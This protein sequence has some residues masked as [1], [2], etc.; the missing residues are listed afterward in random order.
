MR[1]MSAILTRLAAGVVRSIFVLAVLLGASFAEAAAPVSG[2]TYGSSISGVDPVDVATR[3][4]QSVYS[5]T[6][7]VTL[8]QD[9]GTSRTYD[10]RNSSNSYVGQRTIGQ[11]SV[12]LYPANSRPVN[13]VCQD[14]P[15]TSCSGYADPV[16]AARAYDWLKE[17]ISC[18]VVNGLATCTGTSPSGKPDSQ[19][20]TC[21][22]ANL[23]DAGAPAPVPSPAPP[24]DVDYPRCSP[25]TYKYTDTDG[26]PGC[27]A[28]LTEDKQ[29]PTCASGNVGTVNG[30]YTCL[31][32]NPAPAVADSAA[33][34]AQAKADAAKANPATDAAK[35]AAQ[36][37]AADAQRAVDAANSMASNAANAAAVVA[38][39]QKAIDAAKQAAGYAGSGYGG[40]TKA[41][42]GGT[43]GGGGG[44]AAGTD[45]GPKE[46]GT[47]G[48]P[49][50]Q[51]DETGTPTGN[52]AYDG[53]N[54][55]L[56][57]AAQSRTNGLGTVTDANGKDTSWGWSPLSWVTPGQCEPLNYG[58]LG[59][60]PVNIELDMCPALSR[61][62]EL[63]TFM[64]AMGTIMLCVSMVWQ[65]IQSQGA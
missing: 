28:Q 26:S 33:A 58:Q 45:D 17:P 41:G 9:S 35:A 10:C 1:Q 49:K 48:K 19:E 31:P 11:S 42:A 25:G 22:N 30:K 6:T 4:C 14:A 32:A 2:W 55:G 5:S 65:T 37:A 39:A 12:C 23:G 15:T 44:S 16:S 38:A 53:A 21:G 34:A 18:S 7:Q 47:P 24:V 3:A 36:G 60:L 62:S 43:G 59:G 64:W 27:T 40:P 52:G 54:S 8:Y 61:A 20:F 50:C 57:G 46:C 29:V 56:D 51:I 63:I 13:G